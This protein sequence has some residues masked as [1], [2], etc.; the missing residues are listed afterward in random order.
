M[1]TTEKV[2]LHIL[3]M[4]CIRFIVE[5]YGGTM[6]TDRSTCLASIRIPRVHTAAC[7][8]EL[9]RLNLIKADT[10]PCELSL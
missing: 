10:E 4:S 1:S 5:K 8:W 7:F 3:Y 6:E 9:K 2:R